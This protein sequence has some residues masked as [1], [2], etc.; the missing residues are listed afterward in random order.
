MPSRVEV[1]VERGLARELAERI[2]PGAAEAAGARRRR[3]EIALRV[4]VGVDAGGL[5]EDVAPDDRRVGGDLLAAE[6]RDQAGDRRT[7]GPREIA[8]AAVGVVVDRGDH[9]GERSELPARSPMPF[10][11]VWTPRAPARDRPR[12]SSRSRVRSRCGR[13]TRS[14]RRARSSS[15]GRRSGSPSSGE[16]MPRVSGQI[17]AGDA[18]LAQQLDHREDV[19]EGVAHAVRPVLEVDVDG[20]P[21][22]TRVADRLRDAGAMLA[23]ASGRAVARQW[24]S[25]PFVSRFIDLAARP[26]SDPVDGFLAVAVA[27]H[28]D[29]LDQARRAR[30][31][32]IA[33][34]ALT[35]AVGDAGRCD[36]DAVDLESSSSM[37]ASWSFSAG[38]YETL[39]VCSPSRSVVSMTAMCCPLAAG[40]FIDST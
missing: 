6:G 21:L 25:E 16:R 35:L 19:V 26:R 38:V 20:E 12:G 30:P 1:L 18:Q 8:G 23:R 31:A 11:L 40:V 17:D 34:A 2:A 22:A 5:G 29:A 27:E 37:R 33:C 7:A 32:V 14:R 39:G 15:S 36:L 28:L 13:G 3:V 10:T 24:R 9:L 4:A